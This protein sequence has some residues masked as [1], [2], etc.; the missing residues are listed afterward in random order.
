M[1]VLRDRERPGRGERRRE[2]R[3]DCGFH[4]CIP[5]GPGHVL[6]VPRRHVPS[7]DDLSPVEGAALWSMTQL[8]ARGVEGKHAPAV[9]LHLSDGAEAEQDISHVHMH[10]VPRHGDDA[11]VIELPGTRVNRDELDRVAAS[12]AED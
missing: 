8:M 10:V 5:R 3:A 1:L 2:R 7:L 9:N 11:V 4:G 6:I 12:L